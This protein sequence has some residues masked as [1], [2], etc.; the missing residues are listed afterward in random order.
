[1]TT[2]SI[3]EI[4]K[5][6]LESR[7]IFQIPYS[8]YVKIWY[9]R[10]GN[11]EGYYNDEWD[12]FAFQ[13]QGYKKYGN[14]QRFDDYVR[15]PMREDFSAYIDKRDYQFSAEDIA[16]ENKVLASMRAIFDHWKPCRMTN[17]I[18]SETAVKM[19]AMLPEEVP[20]SWLEKSKC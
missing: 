19:A 15:K 4:N 3:E 17:L 2:V 10:L 5:K 1:M 13:Y 16:A 12:R 9:D 6:L 18:F 14:L 20:E 7:A 11:D 8:E